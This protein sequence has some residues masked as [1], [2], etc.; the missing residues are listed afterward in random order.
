MAVEDK[1]KVKT[2]EQMLQE[3][4]IYTFSGD[5]STDSCTKALQWILGEGIKSSRTPLTMIITSYGGELDPCMGLIDI[6]LNSRNRIRTIGAG[7][8][9]S[10][11]LLIFLGGDERLV[12]KNTSILCHQLSAWIGAKHHDL[13]AYQD[14]L[15]GLHEKMIDYVGKRTGLSKKRVKEEL[16]GPT[17]KWFGAKEAV[18]LGIAHK[19]VSSLPKL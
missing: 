4:H 3:H 16:L 1:N 18:R 5:V 2:P 7:A 19:V 14:E 17:D 13:A 12:T 10:A 11:G 9:M 8:I 15:K 6:M